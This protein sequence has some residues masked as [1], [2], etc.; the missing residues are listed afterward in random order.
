MEHYTVEFLKSDL[1]NKDWT[2]PIIFSEVSK[3]A[4]SLILSACPFQEQ[5]ELLEDLLFRELLR[6]CITHLCEQSKTIYGTAVTRMGKL[7]DEL[8]KAIDSENRNVM[9]IL[10]I[11]NFIIKSLSACHE[12][13]QTGKLFKLIMV[14][15]K[16]LTRLLNSDLF[17]HNIATIFK[18]VLDLYGPNNLYIFY[19]GFAQQI[20]KAQFKSSTIDRLKRLLIQ[21]FLER[22]VIDLE[23]FVASCVKSIGFVALLLKDIEEPS[24]SQSEG[25]NNKILR[26]TRFNQVPKNTLVKLFGLIRPKEKSKLVRNTL[27]IMR[28]LFLSTEFTSK[29]EET[30]RNMAE[31]DRDRVV[32]MFSELYDTALGTHS[33]DI[34]TNLQLTKLLE[35]ITNLFPMNLLTKLIIPLLP[36]RQLYGLLGNK[37]AQ[38]PKFKLKDLEVILS[39]IPDTISL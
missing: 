32:Q 6:K 9:V 17:E 34:K 33:S 30:L 2:L 28:Y 19:V 11:C 3:E 13:V 15:V 24:K 35:D 18:T 26:A 29:F 5:P 8:T 39:V 25:T 37:L 22:G 7:A 21:L 23:V 10:E 12:G 31:K 14:H 38:H 27:F 36:S 20:S 16:I 4:D 1:K